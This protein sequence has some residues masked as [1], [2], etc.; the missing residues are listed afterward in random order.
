[1]PALTQA[2]QPLVLMGQLNYIKSDSDYTQCLTTF[3]RIRLLVVIDHAH[4]SH[5]IGAILKILEVIRVVGLI[6]CTSPVPL[7]NIHGLEY[8]YRNSVFP[9]FT[10]D[11]KNV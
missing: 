3:Y 5:P 10:G 4:W 11:E 2:M 7:V 6:N 9:N 1:M 8:N